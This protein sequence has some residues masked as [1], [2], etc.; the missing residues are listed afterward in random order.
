MSP[1][2][3]FHGI[4]LVWGLRREGVNRVKND[5]LWVVAYLTP[6]IS[7]TRQKHFSCLF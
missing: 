7:S 5:A 1:A 6:D 2:L 4:E 3:L